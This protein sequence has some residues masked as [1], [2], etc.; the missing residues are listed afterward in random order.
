M[1]PYT[2]SYGAGSADGT[3][4]FFPCPGNH[5]WAI[6]CS[7]GTLA[8][9]MAYF[10]WLG[11]ARYYHQLIAGDCRAQLPCPAQRLPCP[12][13]P[14]QPP[15]PPPTAAASAAKR[16][17][18]GAPVLAGQLVRRAGRQHRRLRAGRVAA[19]GA[20]RL[21]RALEARHLPPRRLLLLLQ[22]RLQRLDAVALR[23]VGRARHAG[24]PR[25]HVRASAAQRRRALL[26]QRP[27]RAVAHR[28]WRAGGGCAHGAARRAAGGRLCL[29]CCRGAAAERGTRAARPP[30]AARCASP[31]RTARR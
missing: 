24:G 12:V 20:G 7:G 21:R 26:C 18:P 28:V 29:C 25:P 1:H 14:C 13:P 16:R 15:R 22:P 11:G 9:Y 17:R 2:G 31:A 6:E 27:G 30:Q 3:N 8:P 5:D 10:P 23:G 4:H 19:G